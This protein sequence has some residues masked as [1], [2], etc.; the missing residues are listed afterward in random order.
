MKRTLVLV[1]KGLLVALGGLLAVVLAWVASNLVDDTA[2]PV[3]AELNLRPAPAAGTSN[4]QDRMQPVQAEGQRLRDTP[5]PL[6][7]RSWLCEP[8]L[9]CSARWAAIEG[10]IDPAPAIAAALA[11][12]PEAQRHCDLAWA[13]G[14]GFF[15]RLPA[16]LGPSTALPP[17]HP[18]VQCSAVWLARA[19]VAAAGGERKN[20]MAALAQV[21]A[22]HTA[23]ASGSQTLIQ[24]MVLIAMH[25]RQL[26]AVAA[27]ARRHPSW[28]QELQPFALALPRLAGGP[29]KRA[30]N[31]IAAEAA[32]TRGAVAAFEQA[33][34]AGSLTPTPEGEEGVETLLNRLSCHVG[35]LPEAT[36][37]ASDAGW[38]EILAL[39]RQGAEAAAEALDQDAPDAQRWRW[40]NTFGLATV[41]LSRGAFGTYFAREADLEL[42][43]H[44]VQLALQWAATPAPAAA[45]AGWIAR[46][47][48]VPEGQRARLELV[49]DTAGGG[50]I[51]AR[52]WDSLYTADPR[53]LRKIRVPLAPR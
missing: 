35:F 31:W 39:S 41:G 53:R 16:E 2:R 12:A 48:A 22:F 26:Q 45:R 1:S 52:P 44:A 19:L 28:A 49:L 18:Q 50:F 17:M 51:E 34:R 27:V 23:V 4:L 21:H 42:Q 14:A 46:Q 13:G 3:P 5:A 38:L 24:H 8:H 43:R 10:E 20:A 33:C 15:E 32:F 6:D 7:T 11:A 25:R 29:E 37:Q 9:D 30:A 36:R 47:T 40:R